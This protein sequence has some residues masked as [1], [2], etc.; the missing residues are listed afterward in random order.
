M[1]PVEV[2]HLDLHEV[3]MVFIL[4]VEQVIKHAHVAVVGEAQV[5]DATGLALLQQELQQAVVHEALLQ[6]IQSPAAHAVQQV[7]VD[8]V[9]LEPLEGLLIHPQPVFPRPQILPLVRQLGGDKILLAWMSAQRIARH[10]LA[11]AALV[12]RRRVKV[13][14]PMRDRIVHQPVHLLLVVGQPHHA[15]AQQRHLVARTMLHPVGHPVQRVV[16]TTG[17]RPARLSRQH[18]QRIRSHH[19][20]AQ[21]QLVQELPAIHVRFLLVA[22]IYPVCLKMISVLKSGS[23]MHCHPDCKDNVFLFSVAKIAHKSSLEIRYS[24]FVMRSFS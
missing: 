4:M 20:G 9:H 1:A 24:L 16:L 23:I 19:C 18:A 12:H 11:V 15:E 14:H 10:R 13:V 7:V 17:L 6:G 21:S 2:V 3:P 8:V 22:H 5:A